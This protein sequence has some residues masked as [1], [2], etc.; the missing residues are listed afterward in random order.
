MI[1]SSE[2]GK[3]A[4]EP[5]FSTLYRG[6]PYFGLSDDAQTPLMFPAEGAV[7]HRAQPV[8]EVELSYQQTTCLTADHQSCPV[9]L[10]QQRAPL[11]PEISGLEVGRP[12]SQR[13]LI[14]MVVILLFALVGIVAG[15]W[16]ANSSGDLEALIPANEPDEI[17]AVSYQEA[18]AVPPTPPI[19]TTTAVPTP[20]VSIK[21]TAEP[22]L[23]AIPTATPT[24]SLPPTFTPA[25]LPD[26][27]TVT[28]VPP[29]TLLVNVENLN[30]RQG[31][32]TEYPAIGLIARAEEYTVV[33]RITN[34]SWLQIC[35]V[36]DEEG[37]VVAEAVTLQ[38]NLETILIISNIAPPPTATPSESP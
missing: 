12:R 23:T 5:I 15:L 17:L 29:T 31:P 10:R 25:P 30:V 35:C 13:V 24:P 3:Q 2:P 1:G 4:L 38:G 18:T 16:W 9:F 26:T 21:P 14:G 34:G 8:G 33:G 20:I 37:W 27:P 6:C 28:A 11:P 19:E 22:T 32:S 36:N 7:C